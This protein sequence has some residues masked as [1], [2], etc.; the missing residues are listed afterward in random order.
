[1]LDIYRQG[2]KKSVHQQVSIDGDC[3]ISGIALLL[4]LKRK[5]F[6]GVATVG[7][8]LCFNYSIYTLRFV[9]AIANYLISLKIVVVVVICVCVCVFNN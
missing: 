5:W 8:C 9:F 6:A 1:M 2:T 7:F 4:F 3:D